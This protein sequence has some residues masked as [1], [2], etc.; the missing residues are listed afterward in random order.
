MSLCGVVQGRLC[1]FREIP[2]CTHQLP[3]Q[4]SADWLPLVLLVSGER[5]VL[6]PPQ[7]ETDSYV[8]NTTRILQ[9]VMW[10]RIN[11]TWSR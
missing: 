1:G 6:V 9:P 7:A 2:P 11:I 4:P 8:L 10:W 5:L 3:L